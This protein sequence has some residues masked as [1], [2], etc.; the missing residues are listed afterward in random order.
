M[1]LTSVKAVILNTCNV[2][3]QIKY[4]KCSPGLTQSVRR[5]SASGSS[6]A[7]LRFSKLILSLGLWFQANNTASWNVVTSRSY[8]PTSF[9][10][11]IWAER[12][13]YRQEGRGGKK[14]R[15]FSRWKDDGT[16]LLYQFGLKTWQRKYSA[17]AAQ[18][19]ACS[20]R[21]LLS[22]HYVHLHNNAATTLSEATACEV[23]KQ[24]WK[25]YT[26]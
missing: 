12:R 2:A 17:S 7:S 25:I 4:L 18:I 3:I 21:P 10:N 9:L 26:K 16:V 14:S 6:V 8:W 23:V 1:Y 19:T 11:V 15:L 20:L 22:I 13:R 5:S 24:L